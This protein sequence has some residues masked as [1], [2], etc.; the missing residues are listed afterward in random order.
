MT[1]EPLV[2]PGPS[3]VDPCGAGPALDDPRLRAWR[4]FLFAQA[5]VLRTLEAELL[6]EEHLLLGEFD[7]LV[8]LAVPDDRRLRMSELAERLVISRSGVTRLVDRLEGQ[9]LVRRSTCAPDGRGAYA[10]LTPAGLARLRAAVPAHLRH[11]DDHFLSLI[12]EDDLAVVERAMITLAK[13]T[14]RCISQLSSG[15]A[16]RLE[17][18]SALLAAEPGS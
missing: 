5:A 12:D 13:A 11:V 4:A 1:A 8:Q 18:D 10:V 14:G 9:G 3:T 16:G 6:E 15:L 17:D 2:E 7:A